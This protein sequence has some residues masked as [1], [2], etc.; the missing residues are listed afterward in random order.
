MSA[1]SSAV[2]DMAERVTKGGV[3]NN[4]RGPVS[5][6]KGPA[7]K[8]V[9][10]QSPTAPTAHADL[11][12]NVTKGGVQNDFKGRVSIRPDAN[13]DYAK[14]DQIMNSVAAP[15]L[16]M[17]LLLQALEA[18]LEKDNAARGRSPKPTSRRKPR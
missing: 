9:T 4:F 17:D 7:P 3:Q 14:W 1:R 10:K 13:A 8:N 12:D 2:D 18:S 11:V 16:P 15:E 5:I 6:Q